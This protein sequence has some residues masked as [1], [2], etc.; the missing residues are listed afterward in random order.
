MIKL[1]NINKYYNKGKNNEIH[2][3]N[4]TT[5]ELPE[6]GLI[7]F[8]GASGSG[9]STLL[10]VIG[11][12]D[13]SKGTID[14]GDF[15]MT[16]YKPEQIDKYRRKNIGY[17][18]QNYHLLPFMSV[19]D[20]LKLSLNIA[21]INDI[22][23][24]DKRIKYVL[25]SLN[26]Y[27]YR[28]RLAQALSGGQQQRVSIARAL[29]TDAK[30]IL[31]DEPTGN[32]DSK[33]TLEVLNIL[34]KISQTRLVLL[35]T[36]DEKVA[37]FYSDRILRISDGEI[38]SDEK[39]N[40]SLNSYDN[41]DANLIYLKDLDL[42]EAEVENLSLKIYKDE[43][44]E[45]IDIKFIFK[46]NTIYFE[47]S[48]DIKIVKNNSNIKLID[49]HYKKMT[50]SEV[51][52]F[53]Y[54]TDFFK[55]EDTK[56]RFEFK[57]IYTS[58]KNA[59]LN[60]FNVKKRTKFL[61]FAFIGIGFLISASMYSISVANYVD[62]S[63]MS[64]AD[65]TY[66]IDMELKNSQVSSYKNALSQANKDGLIKN[67]H[68]YAT[69][70]TL[71]FSPLTLSSYNYAYSFVYYK[72]YTELIDKDIICGR[73]PTNDDEIVLTKH[74]ADKYL[75]ANEGLIINDYK[76]LIGL[77]CTISQ[78]SKF[79]L[80]IVGIANKND[81]SIYV[82]ST[83]INKYSI[84]G[85]NNWTSI[86]NFNYADNE[87]YEIIYGDDIE[88]DSECLIPITHY[89]N[90]KASADING[91]LVF[92]VTLDPTTE[93]IIV[94]V[95]KSDIYTNVLIKDKDY[96][97]GGYYYNFEVLAYDNDIVLIDGRLPENSAEVI[98]N[99]FTGL[100]IDTTINGY[101]I[102]GYYKQND[103]NY[104]NYVYT[105]NTQLIENIIQQIEYY[106][107]NGTMIEFYN[108]SEGLQYLK[109][110]GYTLDDSYTV[111]YNLLA[112]DNQL[113]KQIFSVVAIV[114]LCMTCVYIFF[115]MRSRLM[116]K[117]YEVGVL[118][119]IGASRGRIFKM[120][121][122]DIFVLTTL[123]SILGY[124][125]GLIFFKQFGALFGAMTSMFEF[126]NLYM[127]L[128]FI[129]IYLLNLIFGM[130]PI[131]LLLRKTPQEILSKY[132]I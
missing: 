31:A 129:I 107:F 48:K 58:V 90:F 56:S 104:L 5:I 128:G 93:K 76:S 83:R 43:E 66:T 89:L 79:D 38:K 15:Q 120:F 36:H 35:V 14:Y 19:Y 122:S 70:N 110:L 108:A 53:S 130:L 80:K 116:N 30:I 34:K 10:S 100:D 40:F 9:K 60:F 33:H 63:Y 127:F 113:V 86:P 91:P 74:E 87:L 132:D 26:M 92:G 81:N 67:V 3:I 125:I 112:K 28:K 45:K 96:I 131:T 4:N 69:R 32:L 55:D 41:D 57:K 68:T 51:E 6:T 42:K 8:L 73:M 114:L 62:T 99:K 98:V 82:K 16:D 75:T 65:N 17:I 61:Y 118:R 52:E 119:S 124:V 123:T 84:Q 21:G 97:K 1:N 46:N 77:N 71:I 126:S 64:Y 29:V 101:K 78:N 12:L 54:N 2:V 47:S 49:D 24:I 72:P 105:I 115:M 102:V 44:F 109:N 95:Y 106:N 7:S 59:L 37:S 111:S 18:F 117:I 25:E 11:G 121:L 50:S 20:N 94:G 22:E 85:Y 39:N 23:E 13:N 27:K 103:E 88:S